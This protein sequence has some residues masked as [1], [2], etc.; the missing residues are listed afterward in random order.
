M[1]KK[2]KKIKKSVVKLKKAYI[3]APSLEKSS[4]DQLAQLAEHLPFKERVLG[5]SPRLVTKKLSIVLNFFF[6]L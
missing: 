4:I 3:F 2:R 5:S 6:C 1:T